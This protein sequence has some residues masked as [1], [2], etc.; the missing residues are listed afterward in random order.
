MEIGT[1]PSANGLVWRNWQTRWSQKPIDLSVWVRFPP[2]GRFPHICFMFFQAGLAGRRERWD[3][4]LVP[5]LRDF[6]RSFDQ[7]QIFGKVFSALLTLITFGC[8]SCLLSYSIVVSVI[9]MI[10]LFTLCA[11]MA[12]AAGAEFLGLLIIIVYVGAVAVFFLFVVM[13]L[14][15]GEVTR[16]VRH[17]LTEPLLIP[18]ALAFFSALLF[19]VNSGFNFARPAAGPVPA[20]WFGLAM[21]R[22]NAE[23]F[24]N[25]LFGP[26]AHVFLLLAVILLVGMLAAIV[27]I[28]GPLPPAG[29]ELAVVAGTALAAEEVEIR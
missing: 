13:M 5:F 23:L 12:I 28:L 2:P 25:L 21:A 29:R 4:A 20:D 22:T 15:L 19:L 18:L 14:N 6:T 10:A 17:L 26:Y 27:L 16:N 7:I 11:V 24:G 1:V 9:V 3:R 8:F